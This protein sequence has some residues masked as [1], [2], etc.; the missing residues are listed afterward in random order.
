MNLPWTH[1]S[2]PAITLP[3]GYDPNG[4]SIGLQVIGGSMADEHLLA[5]AEPIAEILALA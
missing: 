4:L 5:W 3:A 1:A 2:V